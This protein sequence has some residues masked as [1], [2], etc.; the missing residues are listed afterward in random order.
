M[1]NNKQ[2]G[3]TLRAL[4]ESRKIS[5]QDIVELLSARGIGIKYPTYMGYENGNSMPNA[6]MFLAIC[7]ILQISDVLHTFGYGASMYPS[8]DSKFLRGHPYFH[9]VDEYCMSL[10]IDS[11]PVFDYFFS[12]NHQGNPMYIFSKGQPNLPD[13]NAVAKILSLSSPHALYSWGEIN[14]LWSP[15]LKLTQEERRFILDHRELSSKESSAG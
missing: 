14:G 2:F 7:D 4:R 9:L 11:T 13:D 1:S 15:D 3:Q 8:F 5:A 12:D 6:D 10:G